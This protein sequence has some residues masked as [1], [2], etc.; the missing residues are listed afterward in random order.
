MYLICKIYRLCIYSSI[1]S[2]KI[3]ENP[4]KILNIRMKIQQKKIGVEI[5][6]KKNQI[7]S[8]SKFSLEVFGFAVKKN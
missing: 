2:P 4:L 3:K 5:T 8:E 7:L 6:K 1:R